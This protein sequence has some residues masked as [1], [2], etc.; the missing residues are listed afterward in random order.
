[1]WKTERVYYPPAIHETNSE[2][3]SAP[4]EAEV[5]QPEADLTVSPA[6]E[7]A[8]GGELFKVTER[9]GGSNL[10]RPKRLPGPKPALRTLMLRSHLS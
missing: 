1:M 6:D 8:K 9:V 7:P 2:K 10:K 5:A 4:E 3:T